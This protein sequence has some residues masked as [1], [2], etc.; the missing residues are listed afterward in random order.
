MPDDY[1]IL[2][3]EAVSQLLKKDYP[4][5]VYSHPFEEQSSIVAQTRKIHYIFDIKEI[6]KGKGFV[7]APFESIISETGYMIQ[8]DLFAT[9]KEDIIKVL[10]TLS[11][12][13]INKTSYIKSVNREITHDEYLETVDFL[14]QKLNDGTL[15]KIV[16]SRVLKKE[17]PKDFDI[18]SFFL[19]LK[20]KYKNAF[21]FIFNI[22]ESGLWIGATPETLL[23]KRENGDVEIISLAGTTLRIDD[24]TKIEWGEKE[25]QEQ[26]YVSQYI[27]LTISGLGINHYQEQPVETIFA[28]HLAHL[29]TVFVI[30]SNNINGK[31][32]ELVKSLHPTPAVCGLPKIDAYNYIEKAEKHDRKY[33]T[34][35]LGPWGLNNKY[36]LFVNLRC[37]EIKKNEMVLYVGGGLT[38][39]SIPEKEWQETELKAKTL[40]SVLESSR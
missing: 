33:Y 2:L 16:F 8:P 30:P 29:K 13:P 23:S 39:G 38:T 11:N 36:N 25:L 4:F 34:G 3:G 12:L 18:F 27:R 31:V 1:H 40:I 19:K 28:G 32:G 7:I 6:C 10:K 22:P 15:N 21:V 24:K 20:S 9:D 14:I 35:F 17:L 37:A 5:A 26:E